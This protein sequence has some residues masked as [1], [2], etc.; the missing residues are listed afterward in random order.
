MVFDFDSDVPAYPEIKLPKR[1]KLRA[2]V[3]T[4]TRELAIQVKNHFAAAAKYTG[5]QVNFNNLAKNQLL[6]S[7]FLKNFPPFL[8]VSV[9]VGGM[10]SEKQERLLK[11]CP[12]VV[13]AT[14]G[15]LWDL[16]QSGN[17]HLSQVQDIK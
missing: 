2:L 10:S 11:K 9:V 14:P 16:I 13:V 12:E 17:P 7:I 1:S 4:P 15:R 6:N 8:K 3:L 5:I